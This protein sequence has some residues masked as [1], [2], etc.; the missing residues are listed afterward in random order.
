LGRLSRAGRMDSAKLRHRAFAL[1][2]LAWE[3]GLWESRTG[4]LPVS[5]GG[6]GLEAA[7]DKGCGGR[8]LRVSFS[9]GAKER[10]AAWLI[11]R[12]AMPDGIG[13]GSGR[14]DTWSQPGLAA[15]VTDAM[16]VEPSTRGFARTG[17]PKSECAPWPAGQTSGQGVFHHGYV[18]E[19]SP[20]ANGKAWEP[21]RGK[22]AK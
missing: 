11:G 6:G 9:A 21:G 14:G 1:G 4:F 3:A 15:S 13:D 12:H 16:P 18:G 17:T 2:P 5:P 19:P 10:D 22:S 20:C 7:P 8:V